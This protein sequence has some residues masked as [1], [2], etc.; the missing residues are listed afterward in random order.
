M[1]KAK[2]GLKL[3]V[4][5]LKTAFVDTPAVKDELEKIIYFGCDWFNTPSKI[6]SFNR[7]LDI[8]VIAN[9]SNKPVKE[10]DEIHRQLVEHLES[11]HFKVDIMILTFAAKVFFALSAFHHLEKKRFKLESCIANCVEKINL[12]KDD[13]KLTQI[14]N[15]SFDI[16]SPLG[17]YAKWKLKDLE[18]HPNHEKDEVMRNLV[19]IMFNLCGFNLT[20]LIKIYG[21][22][23]CLGPHHRLKKFLDIWSFS[24]LL[25]YVQPTL[26]NFCDT[27]ENLRKIVNRSSKELNDPL[28]VHQ[29]VAKKLSSILKKQKDIEP[30]LLDGVIRCIDGLSF[31]KNEE[32]IDTIISYLQYD[33]E[34]IESFWKKI[35]PC[36]SYHHL[37]QAVISS[38]LSKLFGQQNDYRI[39]KAEEYIKLHQSTLM[40][41]ISYCDT[42]VYVEAIMKQTLETFVNKLRVLDIVYK[43]FVRREDSVSSFILLC[44][45]SFLP[46][47]PNLFLQLFQ[48]AS[49]NVG[50]FCIDEY[51][52]DEFLRSIAMMTIKIWNIEDNSDLLK[53]L[54]NC[55]RTGKF[56]NYLLNETQQNLNSYCNDVEKATGLYSKL[57]SESKD[58]LKT[59][60]DKMMKNMIESWNPTSID[61]MRHKNSSL[62]VLENFLDV[63]NNSCIIKKICEEWS[64]NF[65]SNNVTPGMINKVLQ[66]CNEEKLKLLKNITG[67]ELVSK[68]KLME[69]SD[70]IDNL[71][72]SIQSDSST[73]VS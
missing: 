72:S 9:D 29:E 73:N 26:F 20:D 60:M 62:S 17:E 1:E 40:S 49:T 69:S 61:L 36:H 48:Y 37:F 6:D 58:P 31:E 59:I 10:F 71:I 15:E 41:L 33:L 68:N 42:C 12:E 53:E 21:P 46:L 56:L 57:S 44:L 16:F 14:A 51:N 43:N 63:P 11:S 18:R 8:L 66:M 7:G 70:E 3:G 38:K 35:S 54:P 39:P 5:I 28:S 19:W 34:R 4:E 45:R 64:R 47:C 24:S 55:K 32:A 67:V 13:D 25:L 22:L 65:N 30:R 52:D 50:V 2:A 23:K 27:H